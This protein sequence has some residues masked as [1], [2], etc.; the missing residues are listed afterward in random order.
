MKTLI[1]VISIFMVLSYKFQ[2][3]YMNNK[4]TIGICTNYNSIEQRTIKE[5]ITWMS[6]MSRD[7][8]AP[9]ELKDCIK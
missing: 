5:E 4:T 3:T 1:F 8:H 9:Y 6:I 7:L 2:S